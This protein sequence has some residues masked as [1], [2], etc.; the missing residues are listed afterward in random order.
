M[1]LELQKVGNCQ[2]VLRF[3][4]SSSARATSAVTEKAPPPSLFEYLLKIEMNKIDEVAAFRNL[5]F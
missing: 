5:D 1:E 4:P 3:K 2:W